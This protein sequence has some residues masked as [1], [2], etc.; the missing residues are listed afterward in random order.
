[1]VALAR[2]AAT[3]VLVRPSPGG[4]GPWQTYLLCRSAQSPVLADSWVFPGGTL[5]PDDVAPESQQLFPNDSLQG[6]HTALYRS[7]GE[8]PATPTESLG[9]FVASARELFEEAGVLPGHRELGVLG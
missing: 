5:R 2:L 4:V 9:F 6:A 7:P 3:V 1:M 8:P